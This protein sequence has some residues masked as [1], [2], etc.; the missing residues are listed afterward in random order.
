MIN[1]GK[2]KISRS[3]PSSGYASFVTPHAWDAR[4]KD[5]SVAN[6]F[7]IICSREL[8]CRRG[9]VFHLLTRTVK[10]R[11]WERV[12]N[13]LLSSGKE[14]IRWERELSSSGIAGYKARRSRKKSFPTNCSDLSPERFWLCA[15]LELSE[16]HLRDTNETQS[17]RF[18][19]KASTPISRLK[20]SHSTPRLLC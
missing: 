15:T 19:A 5:I 1:N 10:D 18:S 20:I 8:D 6:Y 17:F 3:Y 12:A 16:M 11:A 13:Y 4:V 2:V 7:H 9:Q 14:N